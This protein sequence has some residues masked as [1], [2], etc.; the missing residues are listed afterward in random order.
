M[1]ITYSAAEL[2]RLV[3]EGRYIANQPA[4]V[5]LMRKTLH[6]MAD[7]LG[8]AKAEIDRL[9]RPIEVDEKNAPTTTSTVLFARNYLTHDDGND[10]SMTRDEFIAACFATVLLRTNDRVAALEA[11]LA[12]ACDHIDD[13]H[14]PDAGLRRESLRLR[15]LAT[16]PSSSAAVGTPPPPTHR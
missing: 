11:G 7:Q 2:T 16:P 14:L 10:S 1:P 3:V 6:A 9:T 4:D 13:L 5:N 15:E 12:V 8:A